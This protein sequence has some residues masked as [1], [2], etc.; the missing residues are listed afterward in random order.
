M[1]STAGKA[2]RTGRLGRSVIAATTAARVGARTVRHRLRPAP[3]PDQEAAHQAEVGRLVFAALNQLRGT[4]LKA[5]QVLSL[6]EGLLP[7]GVRAQLAQAQHRALPLNRALVSR[8]F[9]H[10]FGREPQALYAEFEPEAFAAAS[11]GQV[12]RARLWSERVAVKVQYPGIADT[13]ETDL[14]L[15]R[16]SLRRIGSERLGLPHDDL[17]DKV[18]AE[19]RR[20]LAEEV[21]YRHEATQQAW[22]AQHAAQPD[23]VVPQVYPELS[24]GTVLTQQFLAG[25]HLEPWCAAGPTQAQ[26]DRLAQA[27]WDWFTRCA[28]GLGRI[29]GDLHP[30]N[31]LFLVDGRVG[32]LDFGCTAALGPSFTATLARSWRL[33]LDQGRAG[34]VGL[35]AIYQEMGAVGPDLTL[36]AFSQ[37]VL[38]GLAP[39]LDWATEPF[40]SAVF[41]FGR[42]SGW[43]IRP[44][45]RQRAAAGR[46]MADV[47]LEM[48]SFDRAW[49]ALM[50]LLGRLQGRVD[51]REAA[52]LLQ[53]RAAG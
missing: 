5:A 31:F 8:V 11:L 30:G 12:H 47:P 48:L 39:V 27:V 37:Q 15:L 32:V 41:D 49:F 46:L 45:A 36:E 4:A 7:E 25:D 24:C 2:P 21:D 29:H 33:W 52:R 23:I 51:T 38:P 50:H 10:A 40:G 26:R 43:S 18:L 1:S 6:G 22:F 28:F 20:Q 35:L 34:A 9:R 53:Q 17:V 13:I 16:T 42:K 14:A 19:V 44:D 3:T